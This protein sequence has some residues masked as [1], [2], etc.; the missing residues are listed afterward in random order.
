MSRR[1]ALVLA[2]TLFTLSS[3]A[4]AADGPTY[5]MMGWKG[6]TAPGQP[7]RFVTL[8][9]RSETM[10]A[11]VRRSTGR[12]LQW[13]SFR[14]DWGIPMVA[15][16]GTTDGLSRDGRMLVVADWAPSTSGPRTES[17]FA[18]VNTKTMQVWRWIT[19]RGDFSFDALSPGG[20]TLF[21]IQHVAGDNVS[22]YRVRAYDVAARRLLPQVIA[23]R[24]QSSWTMSGSPVT[25]ATSADGRW[26][27]TL[28]QQP[29][30]YPFVHALDAV[31]RSAVCIG[32]PWKGNQDILFSTRLSLDRSERTLTL[33][34]RQ[35]RPL[36]LVDTRK[37][38]VSRAPSPTGGFPYALVLGGAG[39]AAALAVL[40]L[41]VRRR[42]R[43]STLLRP[44]LR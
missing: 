26:V 21:L 16:D 34:T 38:W 40:G 27:Y 23:D 13:R 25:R 17:R 9:G 12:I 14:G 2:L 18:L 36:F 11:A 19:L 5:L 8:P 32:I 44:A 15:S 10:L 28:Y 37:F 33:S 24:R 4:A 7:L 35:G 42:L 39:G 6:V 29:D 1:V 31:S 30:G 41:A 43:V 22:S 20:G 3:G